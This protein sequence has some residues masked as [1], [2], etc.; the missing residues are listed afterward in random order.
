ML[1]RRGKL[2]K[3]PIHTH[4]PG[5]TLKKEEFYR[6]GDFVCG[7][8][9]TFY[10]RSCLIYDCDTLTKQWFRDN[11]SYEQQ[12]LEFKQAKGPKYTHQI[13][14]Y[15]GYGLEEDSLGS[16]FSLMPKPPKKDVKKVFS[17]DQ[18]ILRFEAKL[19]SESREDNDRKFV[20][21]FFCGNDTIMVT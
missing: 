4:Y 8:Y 1:L 10:S 13:P 18:F 11:L 19:I 3:L 21:S 6:P 7:R 12:P 17:N 5:M 14:P 20:V 16:V 9:L 15:N 2:P